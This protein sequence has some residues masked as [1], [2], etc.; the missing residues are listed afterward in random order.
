MYTNKA[1]SR[2]SARAANWKC[3][4]L[5][6]TAENRRIRQQVTYHRKKNEALLKKLGT[7]EAEKKSLQAELSRVKSTPVQATSS[8]SV[9]MFCILLIIHARISFRSVPKVLALL[10]ATF[11]LSLPVPHYTTVIDWAL[12]AGLA[13]LQNVGKCAEPWI[14]IIDFS[15]Q[16]GKERVMVVLRVPL[17]RLRGSTQALGLCDVE[18]ICV[19]S[20]EDWRS[21]SLVI[22]LTKLIGK[23][24][25]PCCWLS[26]EGAEI[27]AAISR[28][29]RIL[30]PG[31]KAFHIFDV[32]HV[33]ANIFKS[34]L[35]ESSDFSEFVRCLAKVRS[36]LA[37]SRFAHLLPPCARVKGSFQSL[38]RTIEWFQR[39]RIYVKMRTNSSHNTPFKRSIMKFFG[40][41]SAFDSFIDRLAKVT[42]VA[43]KIQKLTK[44]NG[45]CIHNWNAIFSILSELPLDCPFRQKAEKYLK[46]CLRVSNMIGGKYIAISSDIIETLFGILKY[47]S[48]EGRKGSFGKLALLIPLLVGPAHSGEI[49]AEISSIKTKELRKYIKD[50]IPRTIL[51]K[52]R[53]LLR[54]SKAWSRRTGKKQA[55]AA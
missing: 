45:V 30:Y 20:R 7:I 22:S 44:E 36:Q 42:D 14:G 49:P 17:H 43:N 38:S 51:D 35:R 12:K 41:M 27:K 55:N 21:E 10:A 5:V 53:A 32:G 18:A 16:Y 9:Q 37:Q 1:Y 50:H 47:Y 34:M 39:I 28:L 31:K 46:R 23:C 8:Y 13:R 19:E 3:R 11:P 26:D 2:A 25:A 33:F 54:L 4:A 15:I 6:R 40:W 48:D 29:P 24:G 52:R